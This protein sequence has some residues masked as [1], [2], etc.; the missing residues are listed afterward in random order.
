GQLGVH[1]GG[2]DDR[3]DAERQ[4]AEQ[5][6]KDG[7]RQVVV[8]VRGWPAPE[9][10]VIPTPLVIPV[11]IAVIVP[12]II[13]AVIVV[14]LAEPV[15]PVIVRS[16][17]HPRS[18]SRPLVVR[19]RA[20]PAEQAALVQFGLSRAR[21]PCQADFGHGSESTKSGLPHTSPKRKRGF[22]LP[23]L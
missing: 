11:V 12:V 3:H 19:L 21:T 22:A 2:I 17:S 13:P 9:V 8:D 10:A 4:T 15:V 7:G 1:L 14:V 16:P 5:R 23:S 18:P 6:A 20:L